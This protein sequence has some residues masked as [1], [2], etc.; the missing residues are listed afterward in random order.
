[1]K[2][3]VFKLRV[4]IRGIYVCLNFI[5]MVMINYIVGK[6]EIVHRLVTDNFLVY[7]RHS[8]TYI[9]ISRSIG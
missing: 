4:Q 2:C 9:D 8:I 3:K 1:M 6:F 7:C 5:I